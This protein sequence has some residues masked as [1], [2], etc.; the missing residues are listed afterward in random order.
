MTEFDTDAE[1]ARIAR[2]VDETAQRAADRFER[3]GPMTG[4]AQSG[5]GA[6]RVEVQPG[7]Q[8]TDVRLTPEALQGGAETLARQI[9][10]LADTATRRAGD[11][12]YRTLAP[13]LG[14]GAREQ[15][16]S[17]GYEPLPS[18]IAEDGP[19]DSDGVAD[20][21]VSGSGGDGR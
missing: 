16:A 10:Q 9:T 6:V 20:N 8:L 17:L 19:A 7:G 21:P 14:D 15:L 12:M 5:N 3:A 18:D 4:Q 11:R 2:R 1:A 13:A